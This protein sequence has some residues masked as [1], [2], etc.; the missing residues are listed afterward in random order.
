M[1]PNG[2]SPLSTGN[3]GFVLLQINQCRNGRLLDH[4]MRP[5]NI[6]SQSSMVTTEMPWK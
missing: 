3:S 5:S 4:K 2:K 1:K 6:W